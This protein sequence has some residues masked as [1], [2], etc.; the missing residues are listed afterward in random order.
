MN[1]FE[2]ITGT[3][4]GICNKWTVSLLLF[5][6]MFLSL[7]PQFLLSVNADSAA[8]LFVS[9]SIVSNDTA[10]RVDGA[11]YATLQGAINAAQDNDMIAVTEDINLSSAISIMK[12]ITLLAS[13]GNY[14]VTLGINANFRVQDGFDLTLGGGSDT[15]VLTLSGPQRTII[16]VAN[17]NIEINNGA[18]LL[19]TGPRNMVLDLYD[20]K[21]SGKITGG[22]LESS[23]SIAISM[24][25]GARLE[26]IS[27]G[28]I[29][30][31]THSLYMYDED[32]KINLI[33]GGTFRNLAA[34]PERWANVQVD[35]K[36]QIGE[37]SNGDFFAEQEI[38]ALR[39]LR[40]GT[41]GKISGGRF[42]C[43]Y[44]KLTANY[45]GRGIDI[46]ALG[47]PSG[48]GEIS[49]GTF[50]GEIGVLLLEDGAFINKISGGTFLG[51]EAGLQNDI[52]GTIDIISNAIITSTNV[53]L[54]NVGTIN[55]IG[56]NTEITGDSIALWNYASNH[57]NAIIK[58]I[59][60]GK[61]TSV[62]ASGEAFL[63]E[64]T[65]NMIS[66]GI[67]I[68]GFHAINSTT[69]SSTSPAKIDTISGGVFYAQ[70]T[71]DPSF[72]TINL[73]N[74]LILEPFLLTN[75][76]KAR[77]WGNEGSIFNDEA[78]VIYPAD[79]RM[80]T[81]T[82]TISDIVGVG[83]KYLTKSL[84]TVNFNSNGGSAVAEQTDIP[85]SSLITEPTPPIK[86]EYTFSGWYKED[87]LTNAWKFDTDTVTDNITLYAKWTSKGGSGNNN[88]NSN[89]NNN[90]NNNN[91]SSGAPSATLLVQGIDKQSGEIIYSKS[92]SVIVGT[93]ETINALAIE[94]YHLDTGSKKTETITF[95][96]GENKVVF[97]YSKNIDAIP[98]LETG[99]H[100]K[101]INGYPD[102]SVKPGSSITRA[103]AAAIYFRLIKDE[104]KNIAVNGTFS[105]V[106]GDTWYAQSVNYLASQGILVGYR[107]GTFKPRQTITRAE[108]AAIASRFDNLL[109]NE[110]TSF[111]DVSI[112][113]WAA[114]YI[115][116]AYTKG[117]INGYPDGSFRPASSIT[118]AEVVKIINNML[119]RKIELSDIPSDAVQY[120]DLTKKHWAYCYIIEASTEHSYT[121]KDNGFELW[122]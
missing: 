120:K 81:A 104:N 44:T 78:L 21:A 23:G 48:I 16:T 35:G 86:S 106:G 4:K 65:V 89:S 95:K 103:E 80:S 24:T 67:F 33:S 97:F 18:K 105:D 112:D 77:F 54:L 111:K 29:I 55:E 40:G 30:G 27:G 101:Y 83:F 119:N 96:A 116:S 107:D 36:A 88:N 117:W 11:T 121:R 43:A 39:L 64:T 92:S 15:E 115:D 2:R 59:S 108:F 3:V 58:L 69:L 63:N 70:T 71:G 85:R 34:S 37:I 5:L 75:K 60:G 49:G 20:P 100:I 74:P 19:A 110:N 109:T 26:E 72:V 46:V 56:S 79:Y 102:G 22:H 42:I 84:Y 50:D 57:P 38:A 118:R 62:S 7:M 99:E 1:Y 28:T 41:I 6:I 66:G 82:E 14:K 8:T 68:G 61:F 94:G 25:N 87:T 53:G 73:A 10:P 45:Y 122:K 13:G 90:S 17:G 32:T 114:A 91:S 52:G 12:D 98:E 31:K 113:H 47:D 76:G 51:G 9:P 93:T